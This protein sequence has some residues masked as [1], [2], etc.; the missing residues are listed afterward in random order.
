[1]GLL[2]LI[3]IAGKIFDKIFPD[4]LEAEKAKLALL[5]LQQ[6][7]E[8]AYLEAETQVNVAQAATNTEE[9]KSEY[10]FRSCWRPAAAWMG[11]LG[12]AWTCVLSD[13]IQL[14]LDLNG[15]T[16]KVPT[17]QPDILLNLIFGMLG[18]GGMRTFEKFKNCNKV[19]K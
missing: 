16:V 11:V 18:I 10:F 13:I 9:A 17:M 14:I 7:G 5:E 6:K 2:E 1:M 3:P 15:I 19:G 4:K 12:L 8:L